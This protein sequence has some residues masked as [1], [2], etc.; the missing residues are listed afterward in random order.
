MKSH[1]VTVTRIDYPHARRCKFVVDYP[2]P[3]GAELV[4]GVQAWICYRATKEEAAKIDTAALLE[5]YIEQGALPGSRVTV[6]LIPTETVRAVEITEKHALREKLAIYAEASGEDPTLIRAS[7]VAKCDL[8]EREASERGASQGMH[9]R[10][11]RLRLRGAVGIWKGLRQDEIDIDLDKYSPG[12]IA[13]I[14]A[15][16]AGKSTLIENMH[17]YSC[18]LTRDG[19]LQDHFRLRD[20]AREIW[21]VDERTGTEYRALMEIDGANSSGSVKYHL[22]RGEPGKYADTGSWEPMTDGRKESYT[23][24]IE[25]MIGTLPLFLRSAFVSQR[26]TKS[27]PDLSDA[28]KGEKKAIFRE[29]AGLDYIQAY[30][31]S[32]KARAAQIE[33]QSATGSAQAE[34]LE[35]IVAEEPEIRHAGAVAAANQ[36]A[37]DGKIELLTEHGKELRENVETL[38]KAV[39]EQE[40]IERDAKTADA[41][42]SEKYQTV[43]KARAD[44]EHY[45][46][47]FDQREPAQ[48]DI[49]KHENLKAEEAA[50]NERLAGINKQRAGISALYADALKAHRDHAAQLQSAKA[51]LATAQAARAGE[52]KVLQTKIEHANA[53]LAG[54]LTDTCPT[55]GQMLPEAKRTE[56]L[57]QRAQ[58]EER[59]TGWQHEAEDLAR[60]LQDLARQLKEAQANIIALLEPEKPV[61]PEADE[62]ALTRIRAALSGIDLA[63]ARS[64]LET[65]GKAE[66]AIATLTA[67]ID[68]LE[69]DAA[70]LAETAEQLRGKL[71]PSVRSDHALAVTAYEAARVAYTTAK[72]ERATAAARLEAAQAQ[73]AAIAKQKSELDELKTSL[74]GMEAE[75]AEWRYLEQA[76]GADGIQALE[77]DAMGP[78]IS[79]VANRLLSAAYGSR[80]SIELRTTRIAGKGSKTK[81]V[82]DFSIIVIDNE[83]ISE[84]PIETL[85]GG[86]AVWIKRALYDSFALIRD[87]TTGIRFLTVF[88][89]EADGALDPESR[90]HYFA[91][92]EAAHQ[93]SGRRHTIVI[94]HSPEV[95]DA[96]G[97]R[98]EMRR[99]AA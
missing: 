64:T 67:Q 91:M 40:Q 9:F 79:E 18:M 24:A 85:S 17:P 73:L 86:E 20:S 49:A 10:L 48:K 81:Q 80:F 98:I 52:L 46:K 38:A 34:I 59:L 60:E 69:A 22:F 72:E 82:E 87:R 95:Q 13:L 65:A 93:E 8:L 32:A 78:G 6:E 41:A 92:L 57:S 33:G 62:V 14:G 83:L 50:E 4:Q 37:A 30:S 94:T 56:L 5:A 55:C 39:V 89:D 19:K 71:D 70:E 99:A 35:R 29:L 21:F 47:A 45:Q 15:N 77:L 54:G 96:I 12:L 31:E 84:Q 26:P 53:E 25:G 42:E 27:N 23:E 90:Q 97:Q 76:C 75:A 43:G 44:I 61:M 7:V 28:T 3:V 58:K 2:E 68:T 1:T 74:A 63:A 11:R 16:G 88:A 36:A 66:Q 51:Q